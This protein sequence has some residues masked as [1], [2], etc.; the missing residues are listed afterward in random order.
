GRPFLDRVEMWVVPDLQQ[1][2]HLTELGGQEITYYSDGPRET[3]PQHMQQVEKKEQ[4]CFFSMWN[5][6]IPGPQHDIRFRQAFSLIIDPE[7]M[8]RELKGIRLRPAYGLLERESHKAPP[9]SLTAEQR[10]EAA[11]QL[12]SECE[13]QGEELLAMT[14]D[15]NTNRENLTWM[16]ARA[17]EVGIR[18]RLDVR[19]RNSYMQPER[20][21]EA[22]LISN[23]WITIE[24][25][26]VSL[27]DQFK[28]KSI[29]FRDPLGPD[30]QAEVDRKLDALMQF[31][32]PN[33]RKQHYIDMEQW[34]EREAVVKFLYHSNTTIY[35]HP[36]LRDANM[37]F[38]GHVDFRKLWW[39]E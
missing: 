33:E 34:L 19:D 24:D 5:F 14:F 17:A 15:T 31:S 13:Y 6:N 11:K 20:L 2:A 10:V 3:R 36:Q 32:D 25:E 39:E 29:T 35:F 30:L 37:S 26:E 9:S 22:H 27:Y 18:L 4:G 1:L 7:R 21:Y 23:S 8:V 38:Q 28:C 12:L 16:A